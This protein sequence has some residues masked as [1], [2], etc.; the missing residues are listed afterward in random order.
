[1]CT[2]KHGTHTH[3]HHFVYILDSETGLNDRHVACKTTRNTTYAIWSQ[4]AVRGCPGVG[5]AE[6]RTPAPYVLVH[7][8]CTVPP[9]SPLDRRG[10]TRLSS[11]VYGRNRGSASAKGR[12]LARGV[13]TLLFQYPGLRVAF[14]DEAS[15]GRQYSV[16]IRGTG[17]PPEGLNGQTDE[18]YRCQFSARITGRV[19]V[20]GLCW[21]KGSH[22]G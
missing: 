17:A 11:Q 18:I 4:V 14:L 3:V 6:T 13:E 7:L 16:F 5:T 22:L 20:S 15:G 21:G 8:R 9:E 10:N 19:D 12:W 2:R 1:M